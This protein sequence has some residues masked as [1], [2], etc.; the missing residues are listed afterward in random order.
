MKLYYK[1]DKYDCTIKTELKKNEWANFEPV[2]VK[3]IMPLSDYLKLSDDIKD[4]DGE[5]HFKL[6]VNKKDKH[7]CVSIGD[8][9]LWS[10]DSKVDRS[11]ITSRF[12]DGVVNVI[13]KLSIFESDEADKSELRDLI[14]NDLF[15]SEK[16]K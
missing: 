8:D 6:L 15:K 10:I 7:D 5:F 11:T 9:G 13:F 4:S 16:G 12:K 1:Y 3:S 14:I 2:K